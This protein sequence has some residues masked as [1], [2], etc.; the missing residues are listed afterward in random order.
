MSSSTDGS[1][2]ID[3]YGTLPRAP[4]HGRF[5]APKTSEKP[6]VAGRSRSGSRD[7]SLN[8]IL[9]RKGPISKETIAHKGLPPYPKHK[10]TEKTRIY[11]ETSVQTGLTSG[12]LG[13]LLP[14]FFSFYSR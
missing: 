1:K 6:P 12:S 7:A 10:V 4:R 14:F 13:L 9:V 3:A 11:H 2:T 8:R 5:A